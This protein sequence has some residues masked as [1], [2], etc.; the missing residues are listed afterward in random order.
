MKYVGVAL[1]WLLWKLFPIQVLNWVGESIGSVLFLLARER[2]RIG[3]TNLRLCFPD[4]DDLA[5]KAMLKR[6]FRAFGRAALFEAVC[7]WGTREDIS[8][9]VKIEG[10]EYIQAHLGKPLILFSTH[11]VGVSAGGI[12]LTCELAPMVDIYSPIKNALLNRLAHQA[13]QRFGHSE[14]YRRSEGIRPVLKAVRRGLPFYYLPDMDYGRKDA[15]FLPLFGVSAATI[16]GLSRM[17]RATQATVIPTITRQQGNGYVIRLYPP[18]ENFPTQ[19]VEADT[20][21]MNA[22]IE[23]RIREMPEQ[24]FWVHKRFKTRP[25]GEPSLYG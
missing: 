23:D 11:F 8:R 9:L 15:I 4:L 12:R 16:T 25:E 17:A 10:M 20:R 6:H 7:W 22:F 21:R 24:Y 2:R 14:L 1:L 19:D 5:Q 13:R 18:W 3:E